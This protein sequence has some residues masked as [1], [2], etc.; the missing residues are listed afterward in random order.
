MKKANVVMATV[1]LMKTVKPVKQT[2]VYAANVMLV[3]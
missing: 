3:L 2:A 1:T